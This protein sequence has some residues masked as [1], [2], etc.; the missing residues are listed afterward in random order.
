MENYV[1]AISREFGSGGR[2]VGEKLGLELGIPF[3]SRDIIEQAASKSGLSVDFIEQMEER[4]SNSFLF[5]LVSATYTSPSL[6]AQYDIPVSHKAFFAQA[7]AIQE[8]AEKSSCVIVGRCADYILR[9]HPNCIKVFIY[10]D[11]ADRIERLKTEYSYT[12]KDVDQ[13]LTKLDKGRAN[14]YKHYTCENWGS[15]KNHDLSINTSVTG[16]NGAAKIIAT[17]VRELGYA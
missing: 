13:R 1:I 10:A 6:M 5:N 7:A 14:Y 3:Y 2:H 4:A 8:M 11:R 12:A 15:V 17:L 16:I 9:D